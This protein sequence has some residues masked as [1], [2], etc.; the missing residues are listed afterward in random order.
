V[1]ARPCGG[2]VGCGQTQCACISYLRDIL[3][4]SDAWSHQPPVSPYHLPLTTNFLIKIHY[5]HTNALLIVDNLR[6]RLI[7]DVTIKLTRGNPPF[8]I[9]QEVSSTLDPAANSALVNILGVL[10]V[11]TSCRHC[12]LLIY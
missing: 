1:W 5:V 10:G 6:L 2:D 8:L 9:H 11:Q 12:T 7:R 4:A 3:A